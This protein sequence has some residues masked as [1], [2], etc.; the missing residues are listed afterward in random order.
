MLA[1]TN[2]RTAFTLIEL[3]VVIAVI[4]ILIAL[5]L[6]AVQAAREA[7]RRVQCQNN[8]KQLALACHNYESVFKMLPG[9]AGEESIA[10]VRFPEHV[11]DKQMRGFNWLTKALIFAEQNHFAD[12]WGDLGSRR[13]NLPQEKLE[14]MDVPVSILHCPSRRSPEPYPLHGSFEERF[15]LY[16]ARTDYAINGGAA[17]VPDR[18]WIKVVKEGIWRLGMN[19][20]FSNVRDGLSNTY[21][22]GE[23]SMNSN[24][25]ES[26]DDFGDRAPAFGWVDNFAGGNSSIRFAARQPV[27]DHVGNCTSCHDFGSAHPTI[28]SAA[29]ADGSVHSFPYTMDIEVHRATAS[30]DGGDGDFFSR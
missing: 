19:T 6:P 24:K 22:I 8:L 12:D 11:V 7:A 15:G 14:S 3:L 23:K 1:D 5:L 27:R 26:G 17:I 21:L 28:W 4:G 9:Y 30:I 29:L 18:V 16:A 2:K 25:Y 13:G 10:L 20:R